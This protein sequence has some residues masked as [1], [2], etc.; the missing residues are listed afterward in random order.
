MVGRYREVFVVY[1]YI[2]SICIRSI[3]KV[4]EHKQGM[5]SGRFP[6]FLLPL[7]VELGQRLSQFVGLRAWLFPLDCLLVVL[8]PS[9]IYSHTRRGTDLWLC[10]H[11][12]ILLHCLTGKP[13]HKHHDLI[14]HS[15]TLSWHWASQ[16]LFFLNNAEH[17]ARKWQVSI[18]KL[19][20]WLNQS[21]N[22]QGLDSLISP[23]RK[24]NVLLIRPLCLVFPL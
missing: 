6:V 10:A 11:M 21:L 18:L 17:L 8:R 23:N 3:M 20:V 9:N 12:V 13:G 15:V 14:S 4:L 7:T 19:L 2:Y 5:R 16:S 22:P 1:G 24:R